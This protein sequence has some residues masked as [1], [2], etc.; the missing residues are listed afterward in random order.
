MHYPD[1]M[2]APLP[3]GTKARIEAV[4]RSDEDKTDLVRHA[5][6]VELREREKAAAVK[7]DRDE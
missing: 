5:V 2:I 6:E 3:K 4:L 7:A 1:K